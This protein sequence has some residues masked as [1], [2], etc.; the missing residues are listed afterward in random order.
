MGK[1]DDML[2]A[3]VIAISPEDTD[4]KNRE[5]DFIID[6]SKDS[7]LRNHVSVKLFDYYVSSPIMGDESVAI[8]IYDRWFARGDAHFADQAEAAKALLFVQLNRSTL[9]GC[10]APELHLRGEMDEDVT[11]PEA[12]THCLVFF[13]DVDCPKCRVE[14]ILLRNCLRDAGVK[15]TLFA[16]YVGEDRE[17]WTRYRDEQFSIASD[18]V[19]V[20]HV[21]D[22]DGVSEFQYHYGVTGTPRIF[23]TDKEGVIIGRRL[24]PESLMQLFSVQKIQDEL[25]ARAAVGSKILDLKLPGVRIKGGRERKGVWRLRDMGRIIFYVPLC[26]NCEQTLEQARTASSTSGNV[27]TLLVNLDD[28]SSSDKVLSRKIFDT[29]DLTVLPYTIV[30]KKGRIIEKLR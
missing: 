20:V 4:T 16:V 10:K 17:A 2:D 30:L 3:Y 24:D 7:L 18:K 26:S 13:Y 8:H 21:W 14:T 11:L 12:G 29:F 27:E 19:N 6:T 28:L 1:L 9:L 25:D 23:L 15:L 5:V 22:P